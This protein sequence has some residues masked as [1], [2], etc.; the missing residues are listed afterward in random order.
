MKFYALIL[1]LMLFASSCQ[2]QRNTNIQP[3]SFVFGYCRCSLCMT[4]QKNYYYYQIRA[5]A[6]YADSMNDFSPLVFCQTPMP[7]SK[8]LIAKALINNIPQYMVQNPDQN[9]GSS[10]YSTQQ[11]WHVEYTQNNHTVYWNINA[12]TATQPPAIRPYI[13]QL[14]SIMQQIK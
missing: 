11:V 2:K 6:I 10:D 3:S 5:N 4:F 8:Y 13:I 9:F 12:D 1:G 14:D 7:N